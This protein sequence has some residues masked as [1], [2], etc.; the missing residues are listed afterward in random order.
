M[1]ETESFLILIFY[2]DNSKSTVT[3]SIVL[4]DIP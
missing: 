1:Y 4:L 2:F 3:V